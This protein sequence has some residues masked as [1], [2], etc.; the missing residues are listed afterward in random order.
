MVRFLYQDNESVLKINGGLSA[1]LKVK[2]EV[3]QG[4]SLSGMLYVLFIDL[5]CI[6]YGLVLMV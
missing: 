5:C 2:I 1:L 3:Q 4:C 6:K